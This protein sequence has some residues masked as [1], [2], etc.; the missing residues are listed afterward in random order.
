LE[1]AKLTWDRVKELQKTQSVT[2]QEADNQ[3]TLV[4]GLTAEAEAT[5]SRV[6]LLDSPARN[7]EVQIESARV[8]QAKAQ[9]KL[10]QVHLDRMCLRSPISG[11][12]LKVSAE[13]GELAGPT[14]LEP[15]IIVA[16]TS[17]GFVRTFVE[18]LDAR[19]VR[20]GMKATVT[21]DG[22]Q[23]H[24]LHGQI[25][26]LS[27]RMEDKSFRTDRPAEKLDAKTREVWIELDERPSVI[28]LRVDVVI[29]PGRS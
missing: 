3:R 23:G 10:A 26:R 19:E 13:V 15:T 29:D 28:G 8:Q 20:V 18:E 11:Q 9:W 14:S 5:R 21:A 16:D 27:P 25:V 12:V 1:R 2:E 6:Q 24:E 17:R 22:Q 7:D 4:A